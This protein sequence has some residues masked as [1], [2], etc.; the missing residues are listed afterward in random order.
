MIAHFLFKHGLEEEEGKNRPSL[1]TSR[2]RILV[3]FQKISYI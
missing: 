3:F 2:V 1:A